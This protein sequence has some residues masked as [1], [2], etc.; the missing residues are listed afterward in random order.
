MNFKWSIIRALGRY[1]MQWRPTNIY[2]LAV[3]GLCTYVDIYRVSI[4]HDYPQGRS[5]YK[6]EMH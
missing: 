6:T 3:G 5:E 4:V 1:K 2:R